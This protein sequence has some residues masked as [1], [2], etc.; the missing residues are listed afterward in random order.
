LSDWWTGPAAKIIGRLLIII[1]GML[2]GAVLLQIT[3]KIFP[4]QWRQ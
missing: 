2:Y 1:I 4:W 3:P